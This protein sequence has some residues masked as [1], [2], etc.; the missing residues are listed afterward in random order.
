M[1]MA[2]RSQCNCMFCQ[3]SGTKTKC[4]CWV[5]E[6]VQRIRDDPKW[7]DELGLE[8][9]VV[10]S[11]LTMTIEQLHQ[12]REIADERERQAKS[13]ANWSAARQRSK[14]RLLHLDDAERTRRKT[15]GVERNARYHARR[16]QRS[17]PKP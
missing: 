11:L 1:T 6:D 3:V 13:R 15:I 2:Q 4:G 17:V 14:R 12:K 7:A 16:N 10:A 8:P 9:I 5:C